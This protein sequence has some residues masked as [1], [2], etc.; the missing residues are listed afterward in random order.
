MVFVIQSK[1][2]VKQLQPE[3]TDT[4]W[5][6]LSSKDD[7]PYVIGGLGEKKSNGGTQYFQQDRVYDGRYGV[8]L[9][10]PAGLPGGSYRYLFN[11]EN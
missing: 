3:P 1:E 11:E 8:A 5:E 7:L 4:E 6:I 10:L 2:L 9:C